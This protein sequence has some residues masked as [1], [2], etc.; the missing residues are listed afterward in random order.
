MQEDKAPEP[1]FHRKSEMADTTSR[2][3]AG[4]ACGVGCCTGKGLAAP[5]VSYRG[6]IGGL[7]MRTRY[8]REVRTHHALLLER[9]GPNAGVA[10]LRAHNHGWLRGRC[11]VPVP[12]RRACAV[13]VPGGL[14]RP[15][16]GGLPLALDPAL[17]LCGGK[18]GGCWR[19]RWWTEGSGGG[20]RGR[21]GRSA[22]CGH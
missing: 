3:S 15:V 7:S 22:R 20:C 11:P 14:R 18:A 1:G 6:A 19:G 10:R 8:E 2:R 4:Y 17:G 9:P 5:S 12:V 16:R 13:L 21:D